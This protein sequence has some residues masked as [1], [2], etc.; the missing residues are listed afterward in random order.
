MTSARADN[1]GAEIRIRGL[2]IR[3]ALALAAALAAYFLTVQELRTELSGKADSPRVQ[4]LETK[5]TRLEA[6]EREYRMT[7]EEF[8]E[9]RSDV[10]AR[11]TRIESLLDNSGGKR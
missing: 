2:G 3:L 7:S 1:E 5:L 10:I 6:N 4:E 11:L 9:F 8:R